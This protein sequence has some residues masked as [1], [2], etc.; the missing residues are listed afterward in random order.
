MIKLTAIKVPEREVKLVS[1]HQLKAGDWFKMVG[2]KVWVKDIEEISQQPVGIVCGQYSPWTMT[3]L[4]DGNGEK[5]VEY[6]N[7]LDGTLVVPLK[8]A[9]M[10]F[11]YERS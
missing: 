3:L 8:N 4:L 10:N 1:L 11:E 2:G 7:I 6:G 9:S 5:F